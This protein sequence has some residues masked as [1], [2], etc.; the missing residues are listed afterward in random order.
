MFLGM[1]FCLPLAYVVERRQKAAAA[2]A[3]AAAEP[4]LAADG[5]AP[6]APAGTSWAQVAMLAIPTFF[7]LIATVL[8]NIGLLSVT[9]SV[10]Q[11][12]RGAEMLFAALFAVVF[13]KRSL[14]KY[15]YRGI[16]CC[17]AGIALVGASSLLAGEGSASHAVAPGAILFGMALIVASQAVQAAQIT[18]EDFFM[19]I[20]RRLSPWLEHSARKTLPAFWAAKQNCARVSQK[21]APHALRCLLTPPPRPPKHAAPCSPGRPGHPAAQDRRL[22]G[23]VR[24]RRHAAAHAAARAA[25]ARRRRRRRPRGLPRH[26]AHDRRHPRH[27]P[28]PGAGH[29]RPAGL[30]RGRH[31]RDRP[32]G[33]RVPHRAGDDAHAVCVAGRSGAVLHARGDGQAGGELDQASAAGPGSACVRARARARGGGGACSKEMF[34][35]SP[36]RGRC[37]WRS[38]LSPS[39]PP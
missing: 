20:E 11:M 4:L 34:W 39:R 19:V 24:L 35:L 31:V 7:D 27:R 16:G 21:P 18:F 13:L 38:G 6:P 33:R 26:V 5:G 12:L 22:R 30:Q 23:P 3:G 25:P 28:R 36:R 17:I 29:G 2:A 9:A 32:P 37:V 1:T 15:H 10:Y 8:M 14:N